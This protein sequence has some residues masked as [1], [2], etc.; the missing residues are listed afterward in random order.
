MNLAEFT[1][2]RRDDA[3]LRTVD[4]HDIPGPERTL[5]LGYTCERDTWHVYVRGAHL[6]VLVYDHVTRAV[7]RYEKHF[8]WQAAD[9]VP[10]KR[11]YPES[12]DLGFARLLASHG[13]ELPF[14]TFDQARCDRVTQTPFHGALYDSAT[15]GLAVEGSS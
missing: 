14:T 5:L 10:D 1:Q 12:T 15:N 6:H 9:L 8:Y 4:T 11:V 13:V 7:V 2:L 3:Q